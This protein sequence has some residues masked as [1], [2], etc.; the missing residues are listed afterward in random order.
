MTV[1]ELIES[2][3]SLDPNLTVVGVDHWTMRIVTG[4]VE[5]TTL[6]NPQPGDVQLGRGLAPGQAVAQI[7]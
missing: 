3:Q 2:L 7:F 1:A 4:A 5:V 6:K